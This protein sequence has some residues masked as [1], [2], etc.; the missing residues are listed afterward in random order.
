ML[1]WYSIGRILYDIT[2]LLIKIS[3][4]LQYLRIFVPDRKSNMRLFVAIQVAMWSVF[5]FYFAVTTFNI[6]T[7]TPREK[8]WNPLI[9]DGRCFNRD[10]IDRTTGIF[11]C[12]SDF[13][14]LILPM[15]PIFKLQLPLKKKI[16][17]VTIFATGVW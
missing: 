9:E 4:L 15:V 7:C 11:N 1:Q 5:I 6:V 17:M 8:M 3:I 12:L 13:A 14:I 10:A 2:I 16:M